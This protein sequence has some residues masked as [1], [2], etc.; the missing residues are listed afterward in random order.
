MLL[1]TNFL[2]LCVVA[3]RC[4]MLA[5]RQHAI[6]GQPML[7]HTYHAVAL[8]GCFQKGIFVAWQGNGMVCVN[9]TWPHCVNQMGKT[10][11]KPLAERHGMC[12]L[13][14][15]GTWRCKMEMGTSFHGGLVGKPGR[16]LICQGLICRRRFWD[17]CLP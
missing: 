3:G 8:S 4:L 11:S 14:F 15:S 5:G 17:R 10:Q 6:S 7:I 16:E 12:E 1:I 13:A 2:E 9:Q